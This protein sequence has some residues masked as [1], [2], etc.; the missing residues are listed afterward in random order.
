MNHH[1]LRLENRHTGE[2]LELV[3]RLAEG[4]ETIHLNGTLGPHGEGPPLHIHY[5]EDEEGTVT[6]GTLTAEVGGRRVR[7]PA[8][9]TVQLPKGIPH[10]WWNEDD[11]PLAFHGTAR[12]ARDL[13][14]H[15]QAIFEV[16][17]AGPPGRPPL[18]YL[19]H[20]ALRHRKNQEVLAL[21]RPVQAVLFRLVVVAGTLLGKYRGTEW[22]GCPARCTGA[23]R[24]LA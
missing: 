5:H 12:P 16:V 11:E 8:G 22:P 19:A 10:R 24:A 6:R 21:P 13:D 18:F 20:V 1:P 15:L 14:R 2:V 17:N 3:R 9:G 4:V 7:I 23:P